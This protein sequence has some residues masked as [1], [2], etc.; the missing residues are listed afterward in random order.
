MAA[1]ALA[2]A[3][4]QAHVAMVSVMGCGIGCGREVGTLLFLPFVWGGWGHWRCGSALAA[5]IAAYFV[6]N[7][8]K[9]VQR[10]RAHRQN[11]PATYVAAFAHAIALPPHAA[12]TYSQVP[13]V[14]PRTAHAVTS[15]H[16]RAR[17]SL[18]SR[19]AFLPSWASSMR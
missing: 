1:Q 2:R 6:L 4:W 10:V 13:V 3:L 19:K 12:A 7:I 15:C 8:F 9:T 5:S 14:P 16:L 18:F 17:R 11:S